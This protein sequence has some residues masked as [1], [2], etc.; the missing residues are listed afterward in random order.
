MSDLTTASDICHTLERL[1]YGGECI[2]TLCERSR[3]RCDRD[4]ALASAV[5]QARHDIRRVHTRLERQMQ[6]LGVEL[7]ETGLAGALGAMEE[8]KAHIDERASETAPN[9]ELFVP[10]HSPQEDDRNLAAKFSEARGWFLHY[11][12]GDDSESKRLSKE[13]AEKMDMYDQNIEWNRRK[14]NI[15]APGV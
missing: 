13:W 3:D 8:A 9:P 15:E 14:F 4:K 1:C 6:A 5:F 2:D 10:G 7:P 11:Q 12:K